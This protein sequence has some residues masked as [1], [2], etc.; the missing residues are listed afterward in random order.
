MKLVGCEFEEAEY[1]GPLFNQLQSGSLLWEPG[2]VFEQYVGIDY[3]MWT[4]HAYI[5]AL[6]GFAGP[7]DGVSLSRHRWDYI[8][9]MRKT[10]K[11]L[12]SFRLNVFI[13]AKRPAHG[14]RA[15]KALRDLGLKS[16]FWRFETTPHQQ[17][18]LERL[19]A[20]LKGRAIVCYACPTFHKQAVL[21]KWIVEPRIVEHS[22][23]PS[24]EALAGHSAWNF[25]EPGASGVANAEPSRR[26]EPNILDRVETLVAQSEMRDSNPSEE[27]SLLAR[28]VE[29]AMLP[30][31]DESTHLQAMF[32]QGVRDLRDIADSERELDPKSADLL[33]S[34]ATVALFARLHRLSWLVAGT[35]SR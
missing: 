12:P 4:A 31:D 32:A 33:V 22:T 1:R 14:R 34:Y 19:A 23:F 27:L 25:S 20:K 17:I 26:S 16:P 18:A 30:Y 6:H 8:W 7:L 21:Y 5:H 11:R 29:A 3:A 15:P 9:A 13:Q 35:E 28:A 10:K 2:Q 24:V